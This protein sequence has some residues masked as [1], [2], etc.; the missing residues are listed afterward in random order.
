MNKVIKTTMAM[1]IRAAW[2]AL[3]GKPKNSI[4]LGLEIKPCSEC[5]RGKCE[6]CSIKDFHDRVLQLTDCTSCCKRKTC[7][8]RPPLGEPA[9][10][11]CPLWEKRG[12]AVQL[13]LGFIGYNDRLTRIAFDQFAIDNQEAVLT[14]D[15]VRGHMILR[16]GTTIQAITGGKAFWDGVRL[17]QVIVADDRRMEIM[18]RRYQEMACLRHVTACSEVPEEFRFQVYDMDAEMEG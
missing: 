1:R 14:Y 7:E 18:W 2:R 4:E 3:T 5:D 9:R 11:N 13:K 17:D 15:R 12:K 8:Y 6:E 10:I 16:D